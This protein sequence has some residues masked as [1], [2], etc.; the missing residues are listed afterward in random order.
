MILLLYLRPFNDISPTNGRMM[1][2]NELEKCGEKRIT[3]GTYCRLA[4]LRDV[5]VEF[6]TIKIAV[7]HTRDSVY[8]CFYMH[9]FQ[10]RMVHPDL[11]SRETT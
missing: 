3:R 9:N 10:V 7:V 4:A 2:N 8:I 1:L 6:I 5:S 11:A